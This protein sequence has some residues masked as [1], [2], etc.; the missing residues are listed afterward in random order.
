HPDTIALIADGEPVGYAELNRR[1]NRLA[2][3]LSA[4]GL[5]PDQR[6]AICIDRGIDMV[7]AMLA[8]LKAGGA[9]VPLDPAYPSERLDYLLRDCAPVALLTH[10]RLG[11]SMQTRLVLALARL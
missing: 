10:A 5:Q 1:A 6:V 8:V 3:H 11:A 7:V 4:R 2:R 9:Y